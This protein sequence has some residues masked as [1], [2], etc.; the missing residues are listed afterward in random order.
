MTIETFVAA[1]NEDAGFQYTTVGSEKDS[2]V[3]TLDSVADFKSAQKHTET[4]QTS[5]GKIEVFELAGSA[6]LQV[7]DFGDYRL[8]ITD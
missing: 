8:A 6:E 7:M 3:R 4:I 1:I 2:V 5:F